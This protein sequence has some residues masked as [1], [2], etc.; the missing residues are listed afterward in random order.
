MLLQSASTLTMGT[1]GAM[2]AGGP[3]LMSCCWAA[4]NFGLLFLSS[5]ACSVWENPLGSCSVVKKAQMATDDIMSQIEKHRGH[6]VSDW[7]TQGTSRLRQGNTGD[8]MSQTG[9]HRAVHGGIGLS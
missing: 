4:S 2:L 7:E 3:S 6:H 9:K 5:S 1:A 8:I